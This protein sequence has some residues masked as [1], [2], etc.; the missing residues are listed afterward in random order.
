MIESTGRV[1]MDVT[2]TLPSWIPLLAGV[3]LLLWSK[4]LLSTRLDAAGTQS[5]S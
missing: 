2:T 1:A 4:W 5:R 3:A